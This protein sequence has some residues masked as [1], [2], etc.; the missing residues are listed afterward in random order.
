VK[1]KM[2]NIKKKKTKVKKDKLTFP[3][4]LFREELFK[5]PIWSTKEPAF[6]NELNKA[7][8]SYIE[9]AKK[10]LKKDI[11]ERKKYRR[12]S[13]RHPK[14][15]FRRI[16]RQQDSAVRKIEL[17]RG[18]LPS[19][20][21]R[22]IKRSL[23]RKR[24]QTRLQIRAGSWKHKN[25]FIRRRKI[26]G[27]QF[28]VKRNISRSPRNRIKWPGGNRRYVRSSGTSRIQNKRRGKWI[29]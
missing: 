5:C 28:G 27:F 7:S 16:L 3:K 4:E 22:N 29:I 19:S 10:N 11:D 26:G 18:K 21:K 15:I 24:M 1:K 13:N 25:R 2:K 20:V 8:D 23:V 17:R 6:V 9:A 12:Y 14:R